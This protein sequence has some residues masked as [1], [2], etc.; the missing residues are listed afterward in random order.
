MTLEELV[1]VGDI[2]LHAL[3]LQRSPVLKPCDLSNEVQG[4]DSEGNGVVQLAELE[5]A[6]HVGAVG[7]EGAHPEGCFEQRPCAD[8]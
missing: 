5:E 8:S 2:G 7:L 6:G 4:R 1:D 3:K